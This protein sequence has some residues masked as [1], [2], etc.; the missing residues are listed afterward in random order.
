MKRHT[1]K[2]RRHSRQ[3]VLEVRVMSPRIAWLGFLR[4]C[5]KLAKLGCL[6][7]LLGGVAYGVWRGV[8]LA[9]YRNPDFRLKVIALNANPAIDELGVA[10]A[11]GID[12]MANPNLFDLDV[13]EIARK[14]RA[15]PEIADAQVQRHLPGTLAVTVTPRVPRAWICCSSATSPADTRRPG[16]MLVDLGGVAYPSPARQAEI[17]ANLPVVMLP[18]LAAHPVVV[19]EQIGHPE[20]E[21]CLM[22]LDAATAADADATQWIDSVRQVNEW[23]LMLVTRQGTSAVFS[24]GEHARQMESLRAALD[25]AGEK[26]YLIESINLI[27]RYNVPITVR[28]ESAAPPRAIIIK[29]TTSGKSGSST[30]RARDLG[31]LLQRN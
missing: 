28:G 3:S 23:S 6:L 12:L 29:E 19:G 14:L 4:C 7:A 11:A 27:P 15:L 13:T 20:L 8:E 30:R 24:L 2:P 26:G 22:L 25:H 17:S 9:F 21:R 18:V 16:A 31:D 10:A 5:I 1:T